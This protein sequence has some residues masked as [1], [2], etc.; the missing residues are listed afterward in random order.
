[1]PARRKET[2][3]DLIIL[4]TDY[5]SHTDEGKEDYKPEDSVNRAMRAIDAPTNSKFYTDAKTYKLSYAGLNVVGTGHHCLRLLTQCL[6]VSTTPAFPALT[7]SAPA[8]SS[9][10]LSSKNV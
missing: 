5:A 8:V 9:P 4:S 6:A 1:M 2:R 3:H 7:S 10:T